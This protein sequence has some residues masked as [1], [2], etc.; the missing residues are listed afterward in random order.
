MRVARGLA[1]QARD[2][3]DLAAAA[4][5]HP[6]R[7]GL[8]DVEHAVEVGAHQLVPGLDREVLERG[9]ALDPGIVDQDVDRALL[10]LD[11]GDAFGHLDGIGNIKGRKR[12]ARAQLLAASAAAASSLV[13][14]RPLS[15]TVAPA[16]A[17][18]R[19]S[20]SPIPCPEPVTSAR[21]PDRSNNESD[22]ALAPPEA[23][24]RGPVDL[25]LARLAYAMLSITAQEEILSLD[26]AGRG[27]AML[28]AVL[29]GAKDLKLEPIEDRPLADD[30]VRLAFRAGGICGS[31][32]SYYFK[33]RVG[34]FALK[35][36]LVL[37]H[38][39]AG[40]IVETGAA[41]AGVKPGDRVAIDPSRPCLACDYC[42]CRAGQ[43]LPP[44]AVL[45]QCRDLPACPGRL[46]RARRRARRPVP[47]HPRHHALAGRRLRRAARG[48]P[49][50]D[51]AGR[52]DPRPQRGDHRRRADR[53]P[54]RARRPRQGGGACHRHRPGRRAARGGQGLWRRRGRQRARRTGPARPLQGRQGAFRRRHRGHRRRAGAR[55]AVRRG[56]GRRRHRPGRHAAAGRGARARQQADGAR[57]RL[58]GR[59]PV[60][61]RV[62]PGGAA[63]RRPGAST[64][65]RS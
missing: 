37:G 32:L 62:R 39:V 50:R 47:R 31:D 65:P 41:V 14:S 20:A 58:C 7:H 49:A 35:E 59:V 43:S 61:R 11:L 16:W 64:S 33:G 48:L 10:G 46:L 8:A 63:A 51:R 44:H 26:A 13:S 55:H 19:A 36:P 42:R 12:G 5:D 30:E 4:R 53:L 15:T 6:P 56:P 22:I 27:G 29:H 24:L 17:R 23:G 3:D 57:D 18:P 1:L 38:E 60:P 45:R 40:E 28:A 2:V 9:A 54:H 52:R 34:D 25:S 21:R